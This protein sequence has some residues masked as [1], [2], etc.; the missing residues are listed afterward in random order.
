[1]MKLLIYLRRWASDIVLETHGAYALVF[2]EEE[3]SP[4]GVR[5]AGVKA[6]NLKED[7]YVASGKPLNGEKD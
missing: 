5:A 2:N 6:I 1:M 4:V 3:V 7:D